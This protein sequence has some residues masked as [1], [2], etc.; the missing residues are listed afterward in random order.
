M[1]AMVKHVLFLLC[2]SMSGD[3]FGGTPKVVPAKTYYESYDLR[4]KKICIVSDWD[5]VIAYQKSFLGKGC[6]AL[7]VLPAKIILRTFFHNSKAIMRAMGKRGLCDGQGNAVLGTG[8]CIRFLAQKEPRLM[9]YYQKLL[10]AI[11]R[12]KPIDSTIAIYHD[13]QKKY[14]IPIVVWTN[15]DLDLFIMKY[16]C[17]NYMRVCNQCAPLIL[18]GYFGVGQ[19][20]VEVSTQQY[21]TTKKPDEAFYIQALAYTKQIVG[22]TEGDWIYLYIDDKASNVHAAHA[23]A[24]KTDAPI[25]AIHYTNP[26][27]LEQEI[28]GLIDLSSINFLQ[29]CIN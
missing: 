12:A 6:A 22:D 13:L 25:I 21:C 18:D 29:H 14:D 8:A 16:T 5:D 3:F 17:C 26:Q 24:Q 20:T 28:K 9:R 7:G 15:T 23:Y 10:R 19:H 2:L 1:A 11:A 4:G 27:Q